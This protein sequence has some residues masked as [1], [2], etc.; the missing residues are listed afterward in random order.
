MTSAAEPP[1]GG[2]FTETMDVIFQHTQYIV[3]VSSLR[4]ESLTIEVECKHDANRWRGDFSAKYIE[5][6]TSKTGNY[7]K[8]PVFVRM[9]LSAL[10]QGSDSVFVDLLTYADLEMLKVRKEKASS[11]G[12][13]AAAR[14]TLPP[15]NKRYLILTYAA[16]FDRV[17]FPLPLVYDEYPDPEVL[18]RTI[19]AL[20]TEVEALQASALNGGGNSGGGSSATVLAQ[21]LRSLR[22]EN[23]ML[24]EQ[25]AHGHGSGVGPEVQRLTAV[26]KEAEKELRTM[27]K[28]K[29]ALV[30]RADNAELQLDRERAAHRRDMRKKASTIS[31]LEAQVKDAKD[32]LRDLRAKIRMLTEELDIAKRRAKITTARQTYGTAGRTT[33]RRTASG[34]GSRTATGPSSR[35]PSPRDSRGPSPGGSRPTSRPTSR[36]QSPRLPHGAG[37]PAPSPSAGRPTS[38]GS[39]RSNGSRPSSA[40]RGGRFDPTAYV[41]QKREHQR[42][43]EVE[44]SRR[45][46]SPAG[47]RQSSGRSTPAREASF[48]YGRPRPGSRSVERQRGRRALDIP[49]AKGRQSPEPTRSSHR[50]PDSAGGSQRSSGVVVSAPKDQ[51][52]VSKRPS[53]PGAALE[54]VKDRL[55]EY[56]NHQQDHHE[57]RS[58]QQISEK[59]YRE[60]GE[61]LQGRSEDEE[62][63]SAEP[64]RAQANSGMFDNATEEIANIDERLHALQNFLK[65][66]KQGTSAKSFR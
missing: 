13:A 3:S 5:D 32:E 45:T 7:K 58:A 59:S 64:R 47:S 63:E 55:A 48:D 52:A 42:Q 38:A 20:R 24:R 60:E 35:N 14:R 51:P 29:E 53:S 54:D 19:S 4:G 44:R 61:E 25:A 56:A 28:E 22:Q 23:A 41:Q 34:T 6:I 12:E 39:A 57:Y 30:A 21:E 8:Y 16:E 40:G 33:S 26:A 1:V 36:A 9:L 62:V 27:R 50:R 37:R 46:F 17:H 43:K 18:K 65:A 11:N 15:N 10:K 66:A 49:S 2:N 31:E